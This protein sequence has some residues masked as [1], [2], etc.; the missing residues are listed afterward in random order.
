VFVDGSEANV[1]ARSPAA[2]RGKIPET[3]FSVA[4]L[5]PGVTYYWCAD[6]MD[7]IGAATRSQVWSFTT[8]PC[9]SGGVLRE[10]WTSPGDPMSRPP[11]GWECLDCL[12]G[13]ADRAAEYACRLSAW[14]LPPVTADYVFRIDGDDGSKL[15]LSS[16][17]D[18]ANAHLIAEVTGWGS[19]G[20]WPPGGSGGQ[21]SPIRLTAGQRCY[22]AAIDTQGPGGDSLIVKWGH[23]GMVQ[24]ELICTPHVENPHCEPLIAHSPSPADGER[25]AQNP[26]ILGWDAGR[27]AVQHDVYFGKDCDLVLRACPCRCSPVY[28]GR[29]TQTTYDPGPL[30]P[31]KYCWRID[32][33]NPSN[34]A[35]PWR[36][37]V[38][39][40]IVSECE[41][42]VEDFEPNPGWPTG[43]AWEG[44]PNPVEVETTIVHGGAH[45]MRMN[46]SNRTAPYSSTASCTMQTAA[47]WT[48]AGVTYLSLW[49]H[50]RPPRSPA[51][52]AG[53]D[54]SPLSLVVTDSAG[55]IARAVHPSDQ[56]VVVDAWQQWR[57]P[58]QQLDTVNL[59]SVK[60]ITIGVGNLMPD[61]AG[62][63]YI[64]DICLQ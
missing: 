58:L 10:W 21:S 22:I 52:P 48:A 11:D 33:V 30:A 59:R 64:D 6:P 60:G 39:T 31:G 37:C 17:D 62:T 2:A 55:R 7:A 19:P 47:D 50:G 56:A 41:I 44:S 49:I 13:P 20:G 42:T 36:G 14:L 27:E 40:F 15:W 61:G 53:N 24:P 43:C 35:S 4:N 5:A 23:L 34:P 29:Q 1:T 54:P 46:Y 12:K 63:I 45:S 8:A 51:F 38:W 32:E 25:R 3:T 57:I 28:K 16:N 26:I 9:D 18:P